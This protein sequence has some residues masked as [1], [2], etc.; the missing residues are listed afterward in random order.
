MA[1]SF[2]QGTLDSGSNPSKIPSITWRVEA[3][4]S[5]RSRPLM[6]VGLLNSASSVSTPSTEMHSS[7]LHFQLA[8]IAAGPNTRSKFPQ[9]KR[10]VAILEI[11]P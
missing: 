11:D 2:T 7:T 1:S 5:I 10:E 4:N 3:A 8:S 6:A 9:I